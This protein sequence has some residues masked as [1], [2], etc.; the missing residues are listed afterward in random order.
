M[1]PASCPVFAAA[2][3]RFLDGVAGPASLERL[4]VRA[5]DNGSTLLTFRPVRA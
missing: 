4:S 3:R 1:P 2:G 5:F